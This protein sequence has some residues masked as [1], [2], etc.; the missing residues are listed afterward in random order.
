MIQPDQVTPPSNEELRVMGRNC[1]GASSP[2][3]NTTSSPEL[4][5]AAPGSDT[6][7]PRGAPRSNQEPQDDPL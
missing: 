6:A 2:R 3:A 1:A 5:A 7:P 4:V